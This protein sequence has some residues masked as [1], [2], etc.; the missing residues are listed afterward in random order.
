MKTRK[1][2]ALIFLVILF[3]QPDLL[4][5]KAFSPGIG[6][7]LKASTNG[8][9]VDAVYNFFDKMSV[10]LGFERLGLK[11]NFPFTEES[12]D[13]TANV[14]FKTGSI[15]LL[16]SYHVADNVFFTA[17]AGWNLFRTK[18]GGHATS[19]MQFGDIQIPKERIG[20]F[21]YQ[22]DPSWKVSPYLGVGFGRTLGTEKKVAYAFELGGFY[23]GAPDISIKSD[24][25]LSPTSNPDQKHE[26]KLEKQINQYS[27]YPVLKFS[28]SYK[29]VSF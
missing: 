5:Q 2:F 21:N 28:L 12:V 1:I 27:I 14:I 26:I 25:L 22:I 23:Q 16:Y 19:N 24:G 29:I 7:A 9:G 10:R 8:L 11:T 4:A 13:Y 17:G 18:I 20:T 6:L 3:G 15:S